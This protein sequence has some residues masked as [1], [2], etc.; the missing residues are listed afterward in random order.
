MILILKNHLLHLVW[1][2]S[3]LS[4]IVT[5]AISYLTIHDMPHNLWIT[6]S[7]IISA[8]T[9]GAALIPEFTKDIHQSEINPCK[10]SG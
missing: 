5:F 2:T 3:I 9:L 10:R 1:I 8:G 6:L 7:V 4:I